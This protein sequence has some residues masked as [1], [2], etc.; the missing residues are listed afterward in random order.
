MIRLVVA[1]VAALFCMG[2]AMAQEAPAYGPVPNWVTVATLDPEAAHAGEG[3]FLLYDQQRLIEGDTVHHYADT[4]FHI[5]NQQMLAAF[6]TISLPWQPE[7]GAMTIHRVEIIRDGET[8]DLLASGA[9]FSVL[10][11]EQQLEQAQLTGTLTATMPAEGLRLNDVLRVSVSVDQRDSA[12]G[13]NAQVAVPVPVEPV[14]LA[15]GRVRLLWPSDR[16]LRW[17]LP[18]YATAPQEAEA[19]GRRELIV[20][21]P[22]AKPPELPDDLPARFAQLPI[23]EATSFSDWADV[24]TT[25]APLYRAE[26]L[27][28]P[29]GELA[30]EVAAIAAASTDPLARATAALQLVQ[31][32]VRYLYKGM[33]GGNYRPQQ[34]E[35]TWAL[36]YGDCKAKTLLLLA[37]LHELGIEGEA[38]LV[39]ST[40]GAL[41]PQ[42][43]PSPAAF[44]HVIVRARIAGRDFW[45]DGTDL[46]AT[47]A[48]MADIPPFHNALPLTAAGA[49]VP[50]PLTPPAEPDL[51]F[52]YTID[53]RAGMHLPVLFEFSGTMTGEIAEMLRMVK[54]QGDAAQIATMAE[55]L[56]KLTL[57]NAVVTEAAVEAPDDG[58]GVTVTASGIFYP[59][60]EEENREL[61]YWLDSSVEGI[62]FAPNRARSAWRDL[63]AIATELESSRMRLRI[64][65]PGGGE[66]Y[67]LAGDETLPREL[68]GRLLAREVQQDGAW[69]T[70]TDRVDSGFIEVQPEEIGAERRKLAQAKSRRL[71]LI[72][73][74]DAGFFPDQL[75]RARADGMI[76][77]LEA[78]YGA[79]I[80]ADPEEAF[81]YESRGW[82]REQI[83]AEETAL[84]DYDRAIELDPSAQRYRGR[85]AIHAELKNWDA[86]LAD[87][88]AAYE[89]DP[90][91]DGGIGLV[92]HYQA[93]GGDVDGAVATLTEQIDLGGDTSGNL[94]S[95]LASILAD[96]GR[97]DE[98]LATLDEAIL[99]RPDDSMLLNS[100]CWTK[101]TRNRDLEG[102]LRDCTRAI[103]LAESPAAI[104]DSRAMIYFRMNRLDSALADLDAALALAPEMAAGRFLRGV[105]RTRMGDA[106]GARSDLDLAARLVPDI[107]ETYAE[108]GVAP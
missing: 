9:R 71:K 85:A 65:L 30:R 50:L 36:R 104:L 87:A 67:R 23:L 106:E 41:V 21:L 34:P 76:D 37:V 103:E 100:R 74:E 10:Q 90:A 96:A 55:N 6:G 38:A 92:A 46:G 5:A 68:A 69:V 107:A 49:L 20:S 12:L 15:F 89:L 13:G 82:F 60:W 22:L 3:P 88:R 58:S 62:A 1:A 56:A 42:R 73:S 86:A 108:Y 31:G 24:A 39:H 95:S 83:D 4:A 59:K 80:A 28:A 19:G 53:M 33:D 18:D 75:E 16:A 27:I 47:A 40:L 11:R 17:K 32:R 52:D 102:G 70:V 93:E 45:L 97:T 78:R 8:I 29:E 54:L 77:L 44:D 25:M 7:Q 101:G 79:W 57:R 2:A 43:V 61:H 94:A 105:V 91:S 51:A 66:G 48:T 14:K 63:P 98:A 84:E 35:E 64:R 81:R 72:A 26:G 99:L